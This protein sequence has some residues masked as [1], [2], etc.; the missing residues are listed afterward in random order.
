[1]SLIIAAVVLSSLVQGDPAPARTP[2]APAPAAASAQAQTP[3][4]AAATAWLALV[5]RQQWDDSWRTA[6]SL[7]KQQLTAPQ[8]TAT[9]EPVRKPLG[10]VAGR[11]LLAAT[12]TRDLPGAPAGEYEVVQFQTRF[13]Q[14]PQAVE[15]VILMREGADWK[16]AGYFIR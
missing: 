14:K 12:V 8:W 13:T 3:G 1:M 15:T 5:D 7:L 10:A 16:V 2:P 11:V 4:V 6:A 9:V